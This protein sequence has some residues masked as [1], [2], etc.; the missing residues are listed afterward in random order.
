MPTLTPIAFP[1]ISRSIE[2]I[3]A[4]LY[5]RIDAVQTDYAARG[6]L[7]RRMNLNKGVIRGLI[8]LYAWGKWQIYNLL[9]K[10]MQQGVPHYSSGEWLDLHAQS[11]GLTRKAA[12]KASGKVDFYR[13]EG[14]AGNIVI[15]AGRIVRTLPDGQGEIYRYVTTEQV[16]LPVD[17]EFAAV[18]VQ[19]EEYGSG[20]NA[21]VGQISELVTP[22]SGISGV[23]NAADW[24]T[25][26]GADVEEDAGLI[27]RIT[28]RWLGNNG[29]TKYAYKSWALSVPGVIS[30]EI[31]DQ[32]PR[33]QGTVGVV[34]RGSA[35]LPTEALLTRVRAAIAPEAPVNDDWYVVP[36]TPVMAAVSGV[37]HYVAGAGYPALIAREAELRI[38]SLFADKS[39]YPEIT[40]LAIGQDM[41]RDLLT[42]AVM[43]VPGVKSVDWL[44]PVAD[45][46]VPKDGL[47][48][49]ESLEFAA[50]AEAE[51]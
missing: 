47:A 8:E 1:R 46:L 45:V 15:P 24:L 6:W 42:A 20:A 29:V 2:D 28:L 14:T 9:Q 30:V 16:V 7:P 44:A 34:V 41:P 4:G 26:E 18:P 33:G 38:L 5:S 11:V 10:L 12:T 23:S 27:E 51:A 13:R 39:G 22:V 37:L 19:A 48:R 50:F 25:S 21:G 36:P 43:A 31:L 40:P 3:R 32:H 35:V 17:A 49:L